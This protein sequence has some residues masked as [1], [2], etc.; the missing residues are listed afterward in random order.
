MGVHFTT[1]YINKCILYKNKA[2][3]RN[4]MVNFKKKVLTF[5][6]TSLIFTGIS[7]QTCNASES[8]SPDIYVITSDI[9]ASATLIQTASSLL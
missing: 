9:P 3:R 1:I 5:M 7:T 8:K 6:V 4:F 2:N